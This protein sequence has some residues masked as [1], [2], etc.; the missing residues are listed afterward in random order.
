MDRWTLSLR[1]GAE[2]EGESK[3]PGTICATTPRISLETL[4]LDQ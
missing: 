1:R 4:I 3:N 2:T